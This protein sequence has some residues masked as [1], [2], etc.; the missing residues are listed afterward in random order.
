MQTGIFL[1]LF[2]KEL[3]NSPL[4]NQ[5]LRYSASPSKANRQGSFSALLTRKNAILRTVLIFLSASRRVY[6]VSNRRAY[7]RDLRSR[8][9]S[10]IRRSTYCGIQIE[11]YVMMKGR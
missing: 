5:S 7:C 9:I 3:L 1:S 10:T 4:R 8:F 6:R 2:D 11:S